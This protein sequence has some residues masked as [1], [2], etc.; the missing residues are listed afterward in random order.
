MATKEMTDQQREMV[1]HYFENG[2][3][4]TQ[5]MIDAGYAAETARKTQFSVFAYPAVVREIKKRQAKRLE[6][7]EIGENLILERMTTL[8][9]VNLGDIVAKLAEND[10]DLTCLDDNERYALSKIEIETRMEGRGD[11]AVPV[12]TVKVQV[13]DIKA[14]LDSLMRHKGMFQ[15]KVAVQDLGDFLNDVQSARDKLGRGDVKRQG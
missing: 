13:R 11:D 6:N 5:A 14:A 8:A 4:K 9:T 12:K 3:N 10:Y 2:F 7:Y 15:D 1:D